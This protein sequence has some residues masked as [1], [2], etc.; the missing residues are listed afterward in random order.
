[1]TYISESFEI[2]LDGVRLR[3]VRL[4]SVRLRSIQSKSIQSKSIQ[5]D[6]KSVT[7]PS[8]YGLLDCCCIVQALWQR[9]GGGL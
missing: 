9:V 8:E 2:K 7:S 4:P 6:S 5:G 1:M 3:S